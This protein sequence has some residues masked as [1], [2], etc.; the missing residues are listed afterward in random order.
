MTTPMGQISASSQHP[1]PLRFAIFGTGFWARFQLAAWRELEGVQCV[2]L[3]NRT[4]AKAQQLAAQFDIP[5][6]YGDAEA[7]L[8]A[9]RLDFLD[10]ITDVE[11]HPRFVE[12]AAK[13]GVPV[14]CQKPM[15]PNLETARRMAQTCRAA[16]IPLWIHE[17]WRFQTPIQALKAELERAPIGTPF[18]FNLK[19]V[20]G[21]PVFANQPFLKELEQ[22]LIAD[23]G[24]HLFD[25][26]RFLAGEAQSVYCTTQRI[27][28]D[29][30]G[31]DCVT[32]TFIMQSGATVVCQMAYAENF[33]EV[34]RFPETLIFVEGSHGSI[35]LAP[36]CWIRTTTREG[37]F[38]KRAVPHHYAWADP[39]YDLVHASI[40]PCNADIL[41]DVRG[42]RAAQT[43]AEDNLK[44]AELVFAAYESTARNQVVTL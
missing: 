7:L 32:A 21:F 39:A 29:I 44:T 28:T 16:G 33:L 40:V 8:K 37:T 22:F 4:V 42:E 14:I 31:E 24:S 15:A 18:R 23:L 9:E 35:E 38:A 12:M 26:V 1:S 41:A 2:A 6:V 3:F 19:M 34:E 10:I 30:R 13:Y 25:V 36:D 27:H 11:T 17:N 20:T 43:R 5:A